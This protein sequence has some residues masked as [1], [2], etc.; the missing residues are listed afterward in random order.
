M[1][2][3]YLSKLTALLL[4]MAML[5]SCAAAED[6]SGV[7]GT[8]DT[9]NDALLVA[10]AGECGTDNEYCVAIDTL[11]SMNDPDLVYQY[12]YDLFVGSDEGT[13][14]VLMVLTHHYFMHYLQGND[15]DLLCTC[16]SADDTVFS[17]FPM[18]LWP[19]GYNAHLDGCPWQGDTSAEN[20]TGEKL[21]SS[22]D[23]Q[24]DKASYI[25]GLTIPQ[26]IDLNHYFI[27]ETE[28]VPEAYT[29]P[30]ATKATAAA[31]YSRIQFTM[32]SG[33]L[34]AQT[35]QW[36]LNGQTVTTAVANWDVT[37]ISDFANKGTYTATNDNG[38]LT[39]D[40]YAPSVELNDWIV[41]A[42]YT[43]INLEV[44]YLAW[45]ETA[46]GIALDE[47]I[48]V[49]TANQL[50]ALMDGVYL[51]D[52]VDGQLIDARYHIPVATYDETTGVI[53]AL[54]N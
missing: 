28:R 49:T 29:T 4:T 47:T 41:N 27:Y 20:N 14:Y 8:Y 3:K 19:Y 17:G 33:V 10:L 34:G 13:D 45:R 12:L 11:K 43:H 1:K 53:T 44:V 18:P 40:V 21:L 24:T 16:N 32:S 35:H 54:G 6:I 36:V 46:K 7:D 30:A 50:L 48:A 26:F 22:Y 37:A 39:V 15:V 2:L 5:L 31:D 42:G 9:Y 51:A 23:A 52:L 25:A 38:A